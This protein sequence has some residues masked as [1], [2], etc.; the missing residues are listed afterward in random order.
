M[1]RNADVN[2]S[3]NT[4][5][6]APLALFRQVLAECR[7]FSKVYADPSVLFAAHGRDPLRRRRGRGRIGSLGVSGS[8]RGNESDGSGGASPETLTPTEVRLAR[9]WGDVSEGSGRGMPSASVSASASRSGSRSASE[10]GSGSGSG[11]MSVL[12]SVSGLGS[13][14]GSGAG[15]WIARGRKRRRVGTTSG[16]VP[17]GLSVGDGLVR[18]PGKRYVPSRLIVPRPSN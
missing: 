18:G 15:R 14:S 12:A 10:D 6:A 11:S 5:Y 13:A 7:R 4:D 17:E 3:A 2:A 1:N 16:V 8:A 9:D